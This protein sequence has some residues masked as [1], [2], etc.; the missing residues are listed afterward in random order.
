MTGPKPLHSNSNHHFTGR[1]GKQPAL[2]PTEAKVQEIS[3]FVAPLGKALKAFKEN[4]LQA[5]GHSFSSGFSS[6]SSSKTQSVFNHWKKLSE[7]PMPAL[8]QIAISELS[9]PDL[10]YKT[11][12]QTPPSE[13][14]YGKFQEAIVANQSFSNAI[15]KAGAE[16]V[17]VAAE[18]ILVIFKGMQDVG[19]PLLNWNEV[20]DIVMEEMFNPGNILKKITDSL[21]EEKIPTFKALLA[22]LS[23]ITNHSPPEQNAVV[24]LSKIFSAVLF[25]DTS[26]DVK[27][28]QS[29]VLQTLIISYRFETLGGL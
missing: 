17:A 16:D 12:Y 19:D 2:N 8:L 28:E 11:T 9:K 23:Q 13:E 3:S 6:T 5:P 20:Q 7:T 18:F 24:N 25:S 4:L 29:N 10:D 22:H 27:E 1:A 15:G 21:P 14:S 26:E